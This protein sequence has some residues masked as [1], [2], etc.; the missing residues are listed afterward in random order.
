MSRISG[1]HQLVT[2]C[3]DDPEIIICR[4]PVLVRL[5]PSSGRRCQ[6]SVCDSTSPSNMQRSGDIV[7]IRKAAVN[8]V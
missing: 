6:R 4:L 1:A 2:Y 5:F 7:R 8:E 3:L